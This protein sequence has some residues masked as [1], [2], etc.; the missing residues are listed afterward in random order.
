MTDKHSNASQASRCLTAFVDI[1]LAC[2]ADRL[3]LVN[4]DFTVMNASAKP[5]PEGYDAL[6]PYLVV[7]NAGKAI[8]FYAELLGAVPSLK[9]FYPGSD[10][11]MHAELKFRNTV[12]MVTDENPHFGQYSPLALN[13]QVPIS[14]MLYVEDVDALHSRA[15]GLG[16]AN[17]FAPMDMEWGDRFAKFS[18]PFGHIWGIATRIK[19]G[20]APSS[21]STQ[22]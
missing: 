6:I 1:G 16:C 9:T 14:L 11:V 5:I 20:S 15:L 10:L 4:V 13:G 2:F 12:L 19:S 18:D 22:S 8:A 17:I 7:R 21:G 3:N